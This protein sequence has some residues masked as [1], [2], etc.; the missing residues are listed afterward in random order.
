VDQRTTLSDDN[1]VDMRSVYL[2]EIC[3][4]EPRQ[5]FG[6]AGD[7][8]KRMG[9]LQVGCPHKINLICHTAPLGANLA[10]IMEKGLMYEYREF[11][12]KG[13]WFD[14]P[15]GDLIDIEMKFRGE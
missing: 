5:K 14:L 12:V 4:P 1:A 9:Q 6:I 15:M 11:R 2:M 3:G 7:V 8:H 13:E 10:R